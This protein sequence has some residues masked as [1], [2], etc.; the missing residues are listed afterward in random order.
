MAGDLSTL[1]AEE[2]AWSQRTGEYWEEARAL[3]EQIDAKRAAGAKPAQ[4]ST[5]MGLMQKYTAAQVQHNEAKG[6]WFDAKSALERAR[7]RQDAAKA[8]PVPAAPAPTEHV[9]P[10]SRSSSPPPCDIW[11]KGVAALPK[12]VALNTLTRPELEALLAG[13]A[14]TG[15]GCMTAAEAAEFTEH[16][17]RRY[18]SYG[19][20]RPPAPPLRPRA[21]AP[22]V[23][24]AKLVYGEGVNFAALVQRYEAAGRWRSVAAPEAATVVWERDVLEGFR[25]KKWDP[26]RHAL[27]RLTLEAEVEFADKARVLKT[28]QQLNRVG[29]D[30]PI[31]CLDGYPL[32]G[33]HDFLA[34]MPQL[35]K[36]CAEQGQKWILKR[37]DMSAGF[38]LT[39]I[40]HLGA[41]WGRNAGTLMENM[42][43]K[44]HR[45]L[46]QRYLDQPLLLRL[47]GDKVGRKFDLRMYFL[48]A[49]T[50]PLVVLTQR[51]TVRMNIEE[52]RHSDYANKHVH[53]SNI[54]QQRTHPRFVE[55]QHKLKIPHDGL[56]Q[57]MAQD[58]FDAMTACMEETIRRVVLAQRKH[59]QAVAN[60]GRFELFAADF[61]IDRSGTPY[62]LEM[63]SGVAISHDDPVSAA[64]IP[65]LV[66]EVLCIAH[67][68]LMRKANGGS[69][70]RI[71]AAERFKPLINETLR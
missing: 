65:Q 28:V 55:L 20:P 17:V 9:D 39:V 56:Q 15:E 41:W 10:I 57:H 53:I 42:K 44:R 24:F 34:L 21:D 22:P 38:G 50:D 1:A 4:D 47:P 67:E 7:S 12:D 18:R 63:Q 54:A 32:T 33:P 46:L 37:A 11:D 13:V 49:C 23:R 70:R 43:A 51:G 26:R 62:L 5:L 8:A 61:V 71:H 69:L 19:P 35:P 30:H 68:V 3:R 14:G 27:N 6:A 36:L 59:I 48:V 64:T 52:Y 25:E 45:Y 16:W 60:A 40:E 29:G 31:P 58:Q 2:A 66:E